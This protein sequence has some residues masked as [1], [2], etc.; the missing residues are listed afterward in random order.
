MDNISERHESFVKSISRQP[1]AKKIKKRSKKASLAISEP[2]KIITPKKDKSSPVKEQL[3][4]NLVKK[5]KIF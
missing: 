4:T 5:S 2:D 3:S 1:L